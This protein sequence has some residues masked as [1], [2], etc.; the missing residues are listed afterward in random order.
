MIA[1]LT[2]FPHHPHFSQSFLL[3]LITD[4]TGVYQDRISVLFLGGESVTSFSKRLSNLL[5]IP[6][7]H[8]SPVGFD[9]DL[10]HGAHRLPANSGFANPQFS[11]KRPFAGQFKRL[12]IIDQ[13]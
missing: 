2:V 5:G 11:W 3:R 10:W 9:K 1:A 13:K 4:T 6:F 12:T 7:V 8:L